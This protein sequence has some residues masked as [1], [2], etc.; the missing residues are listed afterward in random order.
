MPGARATDDPFR[1]P[2]TA[3]EARHFEAAEVAGCVAAGSPE[4]PLR[5]LEDS[6]VTL[7]AM[8]EIR[9]LCGIT[10]PVPPGNG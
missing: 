9:G 1:E 3:H 7:R 6:V 2:H 8:D 5:T 4:A 10:F